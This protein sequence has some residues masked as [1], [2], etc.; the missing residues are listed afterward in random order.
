MQPYTTAS[1]DTLVDMAGS[2]YSTLYK[3]LYGGVGSCSLVA[4]FNNLTGNTEEL[5]VV[6][7]TCVVH[8]CLKSTCPGILSVLV[9]VLTV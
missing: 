7:L 2:R 4:Q 8:N 3:V 5:A 1:R 9:V 6:L